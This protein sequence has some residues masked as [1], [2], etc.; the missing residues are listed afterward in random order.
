MAY[1]PGCGGAYGG[2]AASPQFCIIVG[3]VS[4]AFPQFI[5]YTKFVT[6]P[7]QKPVKGD[8]R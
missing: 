3:R 5:N 4:I 1:L 7:M 6:F 2:A 8:P